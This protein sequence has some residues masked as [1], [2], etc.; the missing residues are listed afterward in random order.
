MSGLWAG[1]RVLGLFA[2]HVP[3]TLRYHSRRGELQA[4]LALGRCVHVYNVA[5]LAIISISNSVP[6]EISC[7]ASNRFLIFV[8]YGK[9]IATLTRDKEVKYTYNGHAAPVHILLPLGEHLLSISRDNHLIL[10]I[11]RTEEQY[12]E[13]NWKPASFLVTC[14]VSPATLTNKVLLGS[15]QGSMQLWNVHTGKLIYTFAGWKSEITALAQAPAV[16][17]VGVGTASGKIIIHD[18]MQDES[19]MQFFQDWGP[20]TCLTFRTD[21]EAVLA[22]GSPLGHLGIWDL[23]NRRLIGQLRSTHR[24]GLGTATFLPSQSQ[25]LTSGPDNAIRVWVFDGPGGTGRLLSSRCGLAA[26]PSCLLHYGSDGRGILAAGLDGSLQLLSTDHDKLNKTLRQGWKRSNFESEDCHAPPITFIAAE[27]S[28]ERD[29]AGVVA[30]H[31]DRVTV[32]T[33]SVRRSTQEEQRLKP[34]SLTQHATATA[35]AVSSCGNFVV[36]GLSCG[37]VDVYNL[38]S[39]IHRGSYGSDAAHDGPIHGVAIDGLNQVVVTVGGTTKGGENGMKFW[40]FKARTLLGN[41]NPGASPSGLS[42]HRDS[43]L[44]AVRCDDFSAVVVDV[45]LRNMVR[46]FSGHSAALTTSDFSPDG[47]WLV[48]AAM[49]CTVRTWDLPS[50]S[51]VDCFLVPSAVVALSLSPTGDF[52]ATAHVDEVGVFLWSNRKLYTQVPCRPLPSDFIPIKVSLPGFQSEQDAVQVVEIKDEEEEEDNNWQEP[53]VLG[54]GLVTL[55]GKAGS[56]WRNVLSL[57]AIK[58]RNKPKSV[59]V[60]KNAPFFLPT[61]PG[62]IPKFADLLETDKATPSTAVKVIPL[63]TEQSEFGRKLEEASYTKDYAPALAVLH[64]LSPASLEA[65]LRALGPHWAGGGPD[66]ALAFLQMAQAATLSPT[67]FE[68]NQAHLALFLKLHLDWIAKVPGAEPELQR[69]LSHHRAGWAGVRHS[70]L[71]S[72]AILSYLRS[73]LL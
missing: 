10:W 16:G 21:G 8:A 38:Q 23:N 4:L 14:A 61:L 3:H 71:H 15:R 19:L 72:L 2:G 39:G 57:D 11:V 17:V 62:L 40:R 47:R 31:K 5:K 26:Q 35:V 45:T 6:E 55:S 66:K 50:G 30:C 54:E 24:G 68:L 20:V 52:L 43:G 36:V 49:D 37:R 27:P 70:A 32:S 59:E 22:A 69:L 25:L 44:C 60:P 46:R 65:E 53:D 33:W 18:I 73:A 34:P 48:T 13:L 63:L 12:L 9:T 41:L 1:H 67:N 56:Q 29:W 51:L 42:L 28:R 58:E 64:S 7:L